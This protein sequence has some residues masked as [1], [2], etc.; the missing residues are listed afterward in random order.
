[1]NYTENANM[2]LPEYTDV[3]DIEDLNGNFEIIDEHLG[4]KVASDDGAHGFRWNSEAEALEIY[5]EATGE[6]EEVSS[7][8]GGTALGNISN[9]E[10]V[11]SSGT[12]N[13]RWTDPDDIVVSDVPIATW[14]GTLLIRKAGSA[15]ANR[16]DGTIVID[17]KVH[18][19]YSTS[20][21]T[22][23]GLT[24]G[25]TYYYKFFPYSTAKVYTDSDD[26]MTDVIPA[27][28]APDD[29]TGITAVAG[30]NGKVALQWSDPSNKVVS[31]IAVSEWAGTKIV[32]KA[33]SYPTSPEDGTLALNNTTKDMYK[34]SPFTVSGLT[35][36]TT[37]YFALFP[38]AADGTVN[39]NTTNRITCVA[40]R[41]TISTIPSQSSSLTYTGSSQAPTWSNYDS[42]KM[43][44]GGITSGINAGSYSATFTPLADYMWSDGT[45]TSKSV[46]WSIGKATG[47]SSIT[48]TTMTLN[49]TAAF[50]TI[51][52]TRLGDGVISAVSS[53]TSVATVSVSGNVV[54]V[55][56]VNQT[57]GTVTITVSVAAG[58]NHTAPTNKTCAVT[59]SFVSTTLNDNTWATI[60]AV[61]DAGTGASY[62]AVGDA[63]QITISGTVGATAISNYSVWVNIL[64]F[65]HNSSREGT[66]RIHF[67]IGRTAQAYSASNAICLIDSYYGNYSAVAGSFTMNP[68]SG[69][70]TSTNAGG[71]NASKMRTVVLGSQSTPTS[72][73][74]N[75][76]LAALPSDL[77]AVIKACTKYSD[78]T[79]GG[80]DTAGYVTATTDYI[81]LL[82][83]WEVQGARTY[84]NSAE[85]NYQAQYAYYSA[86]NSKIRYRH[87]TTGSTAVWWLRSV[88][89]SGATL[90]CIVDTSGAADISFS[91]FSV[92]VSAGFCV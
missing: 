71:W 78:N 19:D 20:F 14:A 44:L 29:V 10:T 43:T 74:A 21:L 79:G 25:V 67:Q 5:N 87:S 26:N 60:K 4:A 73:T 51:T 11:I 42:T 83:E 1:M 77:R 37:Y 22:D 90:F 58:T 46:S 81:W 8:G 30:G 66:N 23:A 12:I 47:T 49:M 2:K 70:S 41:I 31:G 91:G 72:P 45:T 59:A 62:W 64:G 61:S 65:N 50:G 56:N 27:A 3:I 82:S 39:T 57:N 6:W 9:L 34:N 24:N 48:P 80:S 89:A 28:I 7:G 55:N 84:A 18:N 52:V 53:N 54:T 13:L 38:Y 88:R 68:A 86:G 85:Q 33:G 15:P 92:G 40:N 69:S 36:G 63:K 17:S 35:N 32:Y 75:T 16:K 76:L